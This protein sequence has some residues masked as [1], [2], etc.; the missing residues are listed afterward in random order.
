MTNIFNRI[1]KGVQEQ[2]FYRHGILTGEGRLTCEGRE[3]FV[4]LL[5]LGK[6]P[7]EAKNLM[8]AELVKVDKERK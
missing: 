3:T 2:L 5:F 1:T 6:T 7:E 8:A 4:D